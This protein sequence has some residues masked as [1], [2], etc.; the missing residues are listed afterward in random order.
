MKG[1]RRVSL[2]GTTSPTCEGKEISSRTSCRGRQ[3]TARGDQL[4]D[5]VG[6][7]LQLLVHHLPDYLPSVDVCLRAMDPQVCEV[8]SEL[9]RV[10]HLEGGRRTEPKLGSKGRITQIPLV[11]V[12]ELWVRAETF[13]LLVG[14]CEEGVSSS[15]RFV[16]NPAHR[17]SCRA[18]SLGPLRQ[19]QHR[20]ED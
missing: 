13:A 18:S 14:V 3:A 16:C 1:L 19:P 7:T 8:A 12:E 15:R 11:L 10:A 4:L 20:K 17:R 5:Q 2:D 6:T 9:R